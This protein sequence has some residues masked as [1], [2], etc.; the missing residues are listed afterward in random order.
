[1]TVLSAV[2]TLANHDT[3]PTNI[4]PAQAF[5]ESVFIESYRVDVEI[6]DQI[7]RT[8]IEQVFVNQGDR[9]AE[10]T[11]V[12]PLPEGVT[13]SDLVMVIDGQPIQAQILEKDEARATYDRIVRQLRDPA[14]LEYVGSNAIQANVFPIPAGDK[15]TLEIEYSQLLTVDNGLVN[16]VFPIRTRHLSTLPIGQL[17]IRVSVESND[18]I[19]NIYSPTHNVAIDRRGDKAFVAGFETT[20]SFEANDFSLYYGLA[21][22]EINLNLLTYREGSREDGFFTVLVA[23]PVEVDRNRIIP[24]DVVIVLDQSGSM[25]GNKWE[26][27]RDA[28]KYVLDNLNEEDRFNVVSFSTGVRTFANELQSPAEI[29]DAKQWLSTMEAIGGTDINAALQ[30]ALDMATPERQTVLLFLTDGLPTEGETDTAKILENVELAAGEKTRIFTFGVGDDVDTFLLDQLSGDYRG[31][32]VYVRPMEQI[33]EEVS[34]L[35]NRISAPLLTDLVLEFDGVRV[36]DVYP[37]LNEI[38]DLFIGTQLV[39]VGRYTGAAEEAT[40]R[41]SGKLEDETQV[42]VYDNLEFRANAGGEELIPRLWATRQIGELL[43]AIR[44]H[45]ENPELVDSIVRLSIRYGIITPYTSFLITEDDIL[46][47]QGRANALEDAEEATMDLDEVASGE[48]AVEAAEFARDMSEL[49]SVP[50]APA[51]TYN[52]DGMGGGGDAG[53]SENEE[54]EGTFSEDDSLGASREEAPQEAIRYAG[55]RTFIWREGVWVDT[56]YEPDIMTPE[57]IVFL[58]D[59]YFELLD[60]DE[61]VAEFYSLGEEVIFVLDGQAY[62]IVLEESE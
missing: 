53:D 50:G 21:S 59:E 25:Y 4:Q 55:D 52:S 17:S 29:G 27:A 11:Y 38:P 62:A 56:T 8:R 42:F 48:A 51:P 24:K 36:Y 58:S 28:T 1:M 2:P 33:D 47:Q 26:Q 16:Y 12:F 34:T 43:N 30:T 18:A 14:L 7:A 60:L 13:I 6:T 15:R 10:G 54:L 9:P 19:S 40:L 45:G 32:S 46:S 41:L 23:P 31:D 3:I 49:Q 22:D 44:L 37:E 35:Y 57:E 5:R 61:R 39:I 20:Y